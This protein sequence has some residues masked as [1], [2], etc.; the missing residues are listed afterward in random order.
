[1]RIRKPKHLGWII[2]AVVVVG[3]IIIS[4]LPKPI[5]VETSVVSIGMLRQ[6]IDAEARVR[7]ANRTTISM[8]STGLVQRIALEPGDTVQVGQVVAWYLPPPMDARQRAEA[9]ARSEAA[10]IVVTEARQRLSAIEP[11]LEQS[12]RR[13]ER[14]QRLLTNGAV[15]KEQA[16]NARDA[17]VQL[18]R[19]REALLS[20]ISIA[21]FEAKAA[22]ASLAAQP[23]QRIEIYSPVGGVVLRRFEENERTLP[24]GTPL[25][26]VGDPAVQELVI[27]VLSTDAVRVRVGHVVLVTQWGGE[28]TLRATVRRIEPAA[29]TKVSSLGVEEKRVDVIAMVETPSALLGDAYKV[30]ASIVLWENAEAV[31]VPLSALVRNGDAWYTFVVDDGKAQRRDVTLGPRSALQTSITAGLRR[32]ET[33]ILHPPES[34]EDGARVE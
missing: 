3:F 25:L 19:E 27:D 28:D 4:L 10:T 15:P 12:I 9:N 31:T 33:V 13:N 14:M 2:T 32:G 26:E 22:R 7:Y 24:A 23:G 18:Q 11:Q 30:D 5:R 16:E 6:S 21:D 8:P 34:L 1:M 17:M 20:R 29:R